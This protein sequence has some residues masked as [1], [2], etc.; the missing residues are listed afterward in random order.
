MLRAKDVCLSLGGRVLLDHVSLNISPGEMVVL[1]GQNGAGKSTLFE[2]L[3]GWRQAD[4]G[5]VLLNDIPLH[6]VASKE[7]SASIATVPH[8]DAVLYDMTVSELLSICAHSPGAIPKWSEA[9]G[10]RY[11]GGRLLSSCSAGERA[12]V[13]LLKACV[14]LAL[15]EAYLLLDEHSVNMDMFALHQSFQQL[16]QIKSLGVGLLSITHDINIAWQY[17]DRL[18]CLHNAKLHHIDSPE[19]L[20]EQFQAIYG[21]KLSFIEHQGQPFFQF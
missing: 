21:Q 20:C 10:I 15:P 1:F 11:D 7:R 3:T 16:R 19:A 18:L 2:C 6:K 4:T 5:C 8:Q 12:K 13:N 17:A 14:Q 9:L